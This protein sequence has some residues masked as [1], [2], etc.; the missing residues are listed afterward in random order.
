MHELKYVNKGSVGQ[1]Q[2]H[3]TSQYM[4]EKNFPKRDL[5]IQK[6]WCFLYLTDWKTAHINLLMEFQYKGTCMT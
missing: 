5:S 6:M 3:Y 1:Q 2:K 4:A